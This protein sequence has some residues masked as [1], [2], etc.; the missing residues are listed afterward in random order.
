MEEKT[1]DFVAAA[2]MLDESLFDDV[3]KL[4]EFIRDVKS[5][6]DADVPGEELCVPLSGKTA[7]PDDLRKPD[8][9]TADRADLSQSKHREGESVRVPR[10]VA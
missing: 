3:M 6:V 2:A 10:V 8:E 5:A 7:S 9:V 1:F 4:R